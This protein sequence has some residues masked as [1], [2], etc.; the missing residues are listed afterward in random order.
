LFN[1]DTII[2]HHEFS[3][4]SAVYLTGILGLKKMIKAPFLYSLLLVAV[5]SVSCINRA[6]KADSELL[7]LKDWMC[8]S[9]SSQEKAAADTNFLDIRLEMVEIWKKESDTIWL[10]VE[11]AAAWSIDKPYRQR[12]YRLSRLD[13]YSF[14]SAVFSI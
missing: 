8:G 13:E 4:L 12:V 3:S 2:A 6:E 14:E 5:L 10:Y 1:S 9:F 11:Q 7:Q